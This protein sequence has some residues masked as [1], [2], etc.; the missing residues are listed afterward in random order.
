M[1]NALV[2]L[3]KNSHLLGMTEETLGPAEPELILQPKDRDVQDVSDEEEEM[4]SEVVD[5]EANSGSD[6][7]TDDN[8]SSD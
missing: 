3:H 6:E 8:D 2:F 1:I 7:D 4:Y 5:L